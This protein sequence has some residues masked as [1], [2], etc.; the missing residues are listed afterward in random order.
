MNR[1]PGRRRFLKQTAAWGGGSLLGAAGLNWISPAIWREPVPIDLNRGYWARSQ[2]SLN[3]PPAADLA[4][5]VAVV[6]GGLTGLSAAFFIRQ[7][8]PG[9]TVAVLEAKGC[10]NG[11][12]GRNGAM[13]LN[14]TADRFMVF[15][16]DPAMDKRIYDLTSKNLLTLQGIGAL[17]GIDCELDI[18][19]A[20]QVFRQE[21]ELAAAREYV[22]QANA[23]G[24]PFE[25]WEAA[26]VAAVIG[27]RVYPGGFFDPSAGQVHPMKL[28]HAFKAAAESAGAVV[29]ESTRV[30]SIEDGPEHV[31]RTDAGRTIRAKSLVLAGNAYTANSNALRNSIVPLREYVAMTRPLT[32][33]Q[34]AAIGWRARVPFNDSL[35]EVF[36]L[37]LTRDQRIHIGGGPPHYSF[38]NNADEPLVAKAS[39]RAL[40]R[41]LVRIFPTLAGVGFEAVWSGI[42][43]WSLDAAPAVG[44]TGRH[45]NIFYGIG[46]SGHGVNLT[47]VFGRIISQ[48]EAGRGKGWEEYPFVNR[49]LDYVPNEPFRWLAAEAGLAWFGATEG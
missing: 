15:S 40:E 19:G 9:K 46:Y 37:G 33:A 48:L 18:N 25:I 28:V 12:S 41:E 29:Y 38:N 44:C 1:A 21:S 26:Q 35:T 23:L 17:T 22:K 8:S 20:L 3:P 42:V 43:D 34:L 13:V 32:D 2:A 36:Y 5:D 27:S 7:E 45:R 14:M 47:S 49:H 4:V 24:M 39:V 10:G 31:L 16:S 30:V 11:A 6:G